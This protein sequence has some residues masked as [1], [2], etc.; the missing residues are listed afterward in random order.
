MAVYYNTFSC[1]EHEDEKDDT[2]LSYEEELARDEKIYYWRFN[3]FEDLSQYYPSLSFHPPG[4]NF[5][6]TLTRPPYMFNRSNPILLF[7]N[8]LQQSSLMLLRKFIFEERGVKI[9]SKIVSTLTPTAMYN[10]QDRVEFSDLKL[11]DFDCLFYYTCKWNT[12][13]GNY[14]TFDS[15]KAILYIDCYIVS[16]IIEYLQKDKSLNLRK[17]LRRNKRNVLKLHLKTTTTDE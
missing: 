13:H 11:S 5:I 14:R 7:S 1:S 15:Q 6:E 16:K 17:V 4:N 10:L 8:L 12:Y 3:F 2:G 9:R